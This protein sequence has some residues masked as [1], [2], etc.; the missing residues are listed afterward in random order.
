MTNC[1]LFC[2]QGPFVSTKPVVIQLQE[3]YL[4]K[5]NAI[6]RKP[7]IY[8]NLDACVRKLMANNQT[9]AE[10]SAKA[11]VKRS[12]EQVEGNNSRN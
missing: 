8:P 5:K 11:I 12:T 2:C 3:A 7:K 10:H 9:L 6:G 4:T 1:L